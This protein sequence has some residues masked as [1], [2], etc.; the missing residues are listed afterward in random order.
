MYA[1][2]WW[3][4]MSLMRAP[5]QPTIGNAGMK[6]V[7]KPVAQAMASIW[8]SLPSDVRTDCAYM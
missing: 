6:D 1:D 3:D 8:Y 5:S 7:S 4:H 2:A